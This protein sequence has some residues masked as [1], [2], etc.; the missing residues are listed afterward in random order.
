MYSSIILISLVIV[1]IIYTCFKLGLF[2]KWST[3]I[4]F[5]KSLS[6]SGLVIVALYN[7]SK[8]FNFIIDTGCTQSI[9]DKNILPEI[10]HYTTHNVVAE[11]ITF[12]GKSLDAY[13]VVNITLYTKH[14]SFSLYFEALDLNGVF[15]DIKGDFNGRIAGVLGLDFLNQYKRLIDFNELK[16]FKG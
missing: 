16:I 9:I 8:P 5:K 1:G 11:H 4:S 10:N 6:Q 2:N 7:N 15:A 13:N 3:Q 14:E 12:N